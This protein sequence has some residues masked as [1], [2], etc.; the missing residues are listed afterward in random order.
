M[1]VSA[2]LY[3][4]SVTRFLTDKLHLVVNQEK[5][6]VV[7]SEEFEFLGFAFRKS[8]ATINVALKSVQRFK[9]RIRE[10]TGRSR[11]ISMERRLS[12]L[13][14]YVRGWMGYFGL[15]SQLKL[16]DRLDQWPVSSLA[17]SWP[18][19]SNVLLETMA[20]PA[21][22]SARTHSTWR[23][24]SPSHPPRSQSERLLAH[25]QD[26]CQ[27]RRID[28]RL[29]ARARHVKHENSLVRACSTT[30]NRP[31]LTSMLRWCGEGHRKRWPLPDYATFAITVNIAS[32][33][34]AG[35]VSG[36]TWPP[37]RT[38]TSGSV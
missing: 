30:S 2:D 33:T 26:N 11:G 17:E 32:A 28:E 19:H 3:S 37:L 5:S 12:E 24:D 18:P 7:A 14:S 34:S 22:T 35:C 36:N 13:R 4:P 29:V 25:V 9:H 38:I 1:C 6:R 23:A 20:S 8:R 10:I 15:A 31:V 16:F 21:E 27:R